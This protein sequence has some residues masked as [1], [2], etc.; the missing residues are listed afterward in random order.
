MSNVFSCLVIEPVRWC[1]LVRLHSPLSW[2]VQSSCVCGLFLHKHWKLLELRLL[3]NPAFKSV[4]AEH[5]T[6]IMQ[7]MWTPNILVF[8]LLQSCKRTWKVQRDQKMIILRPH[9]SVSY[10][11][12]AG[13]PLTLV[14][15]LLMSLLDKIPRVITLSNPLPFL[16]TWAAVGLNMR[17]ININKIIENDRNKCKQDSAI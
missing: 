15:F 4:W 11:V 1:G 3:S 14:L 9:S 10:S 7:W 13:W 17:T 6:L 2:Y 16:K 8:V 5:T 12:W